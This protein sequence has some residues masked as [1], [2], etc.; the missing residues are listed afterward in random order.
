MKKTRNQN[1]VSHVGRHRAAICAM[2]MWAGIGLIL[3]GCR[4]SG[5][6]VRIENDRTEAANAS[7]VTMPADGSGNQDPS[8]GITGAAE[9][10]ASN[11]AGTVEA[12]GVTA[13]P[14]R[15][16]VHVCGEVLA[17]GVY[18]LAEGSRVMDAVEAA[19]G[20]SLEAAAETVNLAAHVTD[21]SKVVIPSREEAQKLV[22]ESEYAGW[23]E[24]ESV[25][26]R[27]GSDSGEGSAAL[28][29]IN[30][31]SVQQLTTIPGIGA[32]RAQAIVEYREEYGL[33]QTIED[34]MKV[35]GIKDG[36]FGKIRDY[37][38]VGG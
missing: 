32:T 28:V 5:A 15:I 25:T 12:E 36:L 23:Y 38:T 35:T 29:N 26:E 22:L 24:E 31:A 30:Q 2:L 33:F 6:A 4:G 10:S 9:E 19:G 1:G 16:Y 14:G 27:T 13:E 34:I 20:L 18:E 37:I 7:D 11:P 21:G 3:G 17:P 8:A